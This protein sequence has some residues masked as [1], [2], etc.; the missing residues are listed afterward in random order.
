MRK[1]ISSYAPVLLGITFLLI[2]LAGCTESHSTVSIADKSVDDS[3]SEKPSV[4]LIESLWQKQTGETIK[5]DAFKGKIPVVSMIFTRCA[6]A[7]PRTIADLKNI[8]KQLPAGIK[9]DVVF[10]LISFDDQHDSP[11]QLRKFATKMQT[12]KNWVLLHGDEEGIRDLAMVLN[13]KYKKQPD[14]S[15]THSNMITML[16]RNGVIKAQSEGLGADPAP[17]LT[18]INNL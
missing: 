13:V 17:I 8:E 4:Y 16:D 2:S 9:N 12:G 3:V 18:R 14:G 1:I 6:Y 11:A 5:L 15:F 10:V 7:C